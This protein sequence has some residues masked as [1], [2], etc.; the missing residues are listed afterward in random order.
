MVTATLADHPARQPGINPNILNQRWQAGWIAHPTA[1]S[2]EYGVFHFRKSFHLSQ[3]PEQ[4]VIH[5][6]ADNRYRL[7][8]NGQSVCY[9]PARGDL[10]HWRFETVDVAEHLQTGENVLAAVVWNFAKYVPW[11]Q[12][13]HQTAFIVQGNSDR[14]AMAST[15]HEWKIMRYSL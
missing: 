14:E 7:F 1:S 3:K 11:A 6:S 9:G 13:T 15:N 4:F 8:V 5:V 12:M 10:S 2:K